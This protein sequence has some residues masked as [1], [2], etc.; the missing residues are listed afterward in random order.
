MVLSAHTHE[1]TLGAIIVSP[2]NVYGATAGEPLSAT[3]LDV[4][5]AGGAI[6]V[7]A[8]EDL[9]LGRLD[10]ELNDKRI[11]SANWTAIPVDESVAE[12]PATALLVEAAVEP[13]VAGKD[14]KV[15]RHSFLPGG[16][17][18]ELLRTVV[19]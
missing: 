19:M 1:V 9:Y 18:Q 16:I 7:E 14:G 15:E 2:T 6:V 4:V 8:G 12:D 5:N 13:F 10:L 3:D 17:A 11:K